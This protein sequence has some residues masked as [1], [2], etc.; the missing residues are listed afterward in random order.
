[1]TQTSI[2]ITDPMHVCT[3]GPFAWSSLMMAIAD[4]GDRASKIVAVSIAAP[5]LWRLLSPAVNGT[6]SPSACTPTAPIVNMAITE[7]TTVLRIATICGRISGRYIS[8]PA[9]IAI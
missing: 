7:Q 4:A 3:N 2:T 6:K 5:Q 9:A 1:M 8:A